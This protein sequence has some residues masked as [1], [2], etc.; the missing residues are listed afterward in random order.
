MHKGDEPD[1]LADLR[2]PDV[3]PG[4]HMAEVDL[5]AFE[6]DA[7]TAGYRDRLVVKGIRELLEAAVDAR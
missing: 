4:K 3:L 1:A 7:A 5:P 2:H 6:A